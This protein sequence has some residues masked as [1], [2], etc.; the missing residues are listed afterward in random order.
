MP[1]RGEPLEIGKG[2]IVQT[3]GRVAILS[4]GTRLGEVLKASEALRAKGITPTIADARFAKPL[5]TELVLDLAREHEALITIEEGSIGGFGSHVAQC[6]AEAGAFDE[7]LKFRSMI[8]P[9]S[10]LDQSSPADMYATAGL[11]A[12]DIEAKVLDVLG[13]SQIDSKRA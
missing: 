4:F 3:G 6:L 10:F 12:D 1:E 11:Q 9:D 7:G 13:V 5:D 2:R 8:L